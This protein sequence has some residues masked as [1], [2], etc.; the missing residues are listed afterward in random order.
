MQRSPSDYPRQK[1]HNILLVE[2]TVTDEILIKAAFERRG[3]LSDINEVIQ[4]GEAAIERL[5]DHNK[6]LPSLVLL[7]LNL[8]KCSGFEVL[9]RVKEDDRAKVVPIIVL[10]TSDRDEDVLGSWQNHCN[11]Y[12][13]KSA[14]FGDLVQRVEAYWFEVQANTLPSLITS[15]V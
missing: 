2:D 12:I 11:S 3:R 14:N 8:P 4:D 9:Q 6:P 7:D 1:S 13:Q 10:S 5:L 15:S